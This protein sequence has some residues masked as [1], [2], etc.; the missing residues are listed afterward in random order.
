MNWTDDEGN[1]EKTSLRW[2]DRK[3]YFWLYSWNG[4]CDGDPVEC[5]QFNYPLAGRYRCDVAET[6]R[7]HGNDYT[8]IN[9]Y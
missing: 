3:P 8:D 5:S 1:N 6:C 7:D 2:D 9:N 4:S